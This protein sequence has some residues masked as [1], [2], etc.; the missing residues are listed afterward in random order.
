MRAVPLAALLLLLSA[1]PAPGADLTLDPEPVPMP[2]M[3][4]C[5]VPIINRGLG[6]TLGSPASTPTC[7]SATALLP[8]FARLRET[9]GFGPDDLRF[10]VDAGER[11]ANAS[12]LEKV[13]TI[14]VPFLKDETMG[15]NARL[16]AIAHEIGHAV[17]DRD[18]LIDWR[19]EPRTAFVQRAR[20]LN[21]VPAFEGSPEEAEF[22]ARSRRLEAHADAIGQ[23]LLLAAGY[24][25]DV[26]ARGEAEFFGC[27]GVETLEGD[28]RTH[29]VDAQRYINSNLTG[30]ALANERARAALKNQTDFAGRPAP[31]DAVAAAA[32]LKP[33]K[34]NA[35]LHDYDD[36][37]RVL[38]G[39]RIAQIL[40][41]PLPPPDAGPIRR[42]AT[43]I[44]YSTVDYW[45]VKPL[46]EAVNRLSTQD[47]VATQVLASCG[48]PETLTAAEEFSVGGWT[49]RIAADAASRMTRWLRPNE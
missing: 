45:L 24:T 47:G 28:G 5:S 23:E 48:N 39:R 29:P 31:G 11:K 7:R 2:A 10:A 43:L 36:D 32:T 33:F 6:M 46:R 42:H 21:P 1:P 18:K 3:E 26:F 30:G 16:M 27:H 14:S 41:V 8:D 35:S 44:A 13:V 9:A 25:A 19:N 17:Q 15:L 12:Y 37:G 40:Q 22:M 38:P 49:R 4:P 20:N 34:P